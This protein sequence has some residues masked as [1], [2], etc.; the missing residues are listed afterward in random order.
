MKFP[1]LLLG[2]LLLLVV[3]ACGETTKKEDEFRITGHVRGL[4]GKK[5]FLERFVGVKSEPVQEV[6]V[7][8]KGNF[9]ITA[10]GEANAIYQLRM[11]EGGRM[12]LFPEFSTLNIEADADELE[13]YHATGSARNQILRDFNLGQY[14]LYIDFASAESRLDGLDRTK[15]TTA[16]H[17]LE[18]VTDKAMMAYRAYIRTFIDTVSIPVMRAHAALSLTIN[19]NYH[20]VSK[21]ADRLDQE[22]PGSPAVAEL[23]KGLAKEADRRI[24]EVGTPIT[25]TDVNGKPFDLFALRGKNILLQFWASYCEFS[26]VE[27]TKLAGLEALFTANNTVLVLFSI[28][29]TDAEWRNYL[30]TADL[31]WATHIRGGNG[32]SSTEIQQYLVR[33]IPANYFLDGNGVIRDLDIRSNELET[34]LPALA[35]TAGPT[36]PA[37]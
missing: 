13:A 23:R 6:P 29:D 4:E 33:A 27:N 20:Y 37:H 1:H 25:G 31:D 22:M 16:W 17:E 2:M 14:R 18:A 24:G 28:D 35:K 36:P 30:K 3:S 19:G 32:T 11:N 8:E 26:R 21:V 9:E 7:D 34:D 10:N 15:D 5:L 12:L